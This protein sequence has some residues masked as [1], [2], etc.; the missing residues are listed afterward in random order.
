MTDAHQDVARL[1]ARLRF[2][3]DRCGIQFSKGV[4]T[5]ITEAADRL[6]SLSQALREAEAERGEWKQAAQVEAGLRREFLARAE[7]AESRLAEAMN[8]IQQIDKICRT[9][10]PAALNAGRHFQR[11]FD[12]IRDLCARAFIAGNGGKDGI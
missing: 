2:D 9:P 4:A 3:A 6:E 7:A 5:N 12:A 1:V 8:R 10:T 11:D